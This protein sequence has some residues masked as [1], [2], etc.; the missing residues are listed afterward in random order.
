MSLYN[1]RLCMMCLYDDEMC[2]YTYIRTSLHRVC[3][4]FGRTQKTPAP[5]SDSASTSCRSRPEKKN[6]VGGTVE[7]DSWGTA[8]CMYVMVC[9]R[10]PRKKHTTTCRGKPM[11]FGRNRTGSLPRYRC[12]TCWF[13]GGWYIHSIFQHIL[14]EN[15][16]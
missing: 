4:D 16:L 5:G 12:S 9:M 15:H 7:R 13:T 1:V 8:Q 3:S 10:Y 6:A 14:D 2:V 11:V